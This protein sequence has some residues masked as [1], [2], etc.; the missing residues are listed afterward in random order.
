MIMPEWSN[1]NALAKAVYGRSWLTA[2]VYVQ[3]VVSWKF[4]GVVMPH[5][6]GNYIFGVNNFL[7]TSPWGHDQSTV[8]VLVG[9]DR[10][11]VRS[12]GTTFTKYFPGR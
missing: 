2:Y 8:L 4:I 9:C 10:G 3:W 6:F 7:L 12:L 1:R 11:H 5:H